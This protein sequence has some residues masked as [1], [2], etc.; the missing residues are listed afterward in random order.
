MKPKP[1]TLTIR[2]EHAGD[3]SNFGFVHDAD[4]RQILWADELLR[5]LG[6]RFPKQKATVTLSLDLKVTKKGRS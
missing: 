5:M 4:G 6:V 1:L 3:R 2:H